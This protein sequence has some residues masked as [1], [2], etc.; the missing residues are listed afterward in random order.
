M[1]YIGVHKQPLDKTSFFYVDW[2]DKSNIV[3]L[4]ISVILFVFGFYYIFKALGF[5]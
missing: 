3:G 5:L 2:G 1:P 4:A